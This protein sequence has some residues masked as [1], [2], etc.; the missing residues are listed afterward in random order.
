MSGFTLIF[1]IIN[2]L[3]LVALLRRFLF[4]PVS[5]MVTR[6]QQETERATAEGARLRGEAAEL[7]AAAE[8]DLAQ[9]AEGRARLL[10]EARAEAER[11][12]GVALAEAHRE[13]EAT[14]ERARR[15]IESE[16][17]KA[18][19]AMAKG[20][21][22]IGLTVARRLLAQTVTAPIL[23]AFLA[24]LCEDLD[25]LPEE[26]RRALREDVGAADLVLATAPA[27]EAAG[28]RRWLSEIEARLGNGSHLRLVADES[29][30][31]G[32]ELRFPHEAISFCWRD[33]LQAARRELMGP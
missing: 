1:Q 11:E 16:R 32:A 8:K 22:E 23:D 18:A 5:A 2:F 21:V 31:A 27:L 12:R 15:D 10:G 4:K 33:G 20:A 28:A 14:L 24:R 6:R 17:E 30:L 25:R 9:A 7:R 3:V 26:R 19:E 13:A 29:L